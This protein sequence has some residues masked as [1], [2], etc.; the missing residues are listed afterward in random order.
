[1][2]DRRIVLFE[3]TGGWVRMD[4]G[5]P[6][7]NGMVTEKDKLQALLKRKCTDPYQVP[8][9]IASGRWQLKCHVVSEGAPSEYQ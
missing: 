5:Q 2:T 3:G 1:M 4:I 6:P 7:Y 9:L 8:K